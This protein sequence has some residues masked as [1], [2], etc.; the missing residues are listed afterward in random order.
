MKYELTGGE[1]GSFTHTTGPYSGPLRFAALA[2][3]GFVFAAILKFV[4]GRQTPYFDPS[5]EYF[6]IAILLLALVAFGP[7]VAI[8]WSDSK[9]CISLTV[10]H[11]VRKVVLAFRNLKGISEES[12]DFTEVERFRV[13]RRQHGSLSDWYLYLETTL[14]DEPVVAKFRE[15]HDAERE[16]DEANRALFRGKTWRIEG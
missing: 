16:N 1:R 13:E 10:D 15:A 5:N 8:L 9:E 4:V 14:E 7:P 2:V 11:E 3:V 6:P 12:Y